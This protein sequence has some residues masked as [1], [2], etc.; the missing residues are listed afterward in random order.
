MKREAQKPGRNM[1]AHA[2]RIEQ[3]QRLLNLHVAEMHE[4]LTKKGAAAAALMMARRTASKLYQQPDLMK[5]FFDDWAAQK[6]ARAGQ[7]PARA[8]WYHNVARELA[9]LHSE[10]GRP[11]P[12]QLQFVA[13][14]L[15]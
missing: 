11:L 5:T 1:L 10:E 4:S 2:A 3:A 14:F 12:P 13:E 9:A 8:G 7:K 15:R 6:P